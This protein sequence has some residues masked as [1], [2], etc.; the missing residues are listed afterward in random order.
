LFVKDDDKRRRNF[1]REPPDMQLCPWLDY[2][3]RLLPKILG[4][5]CN[6]AASLG[7]NSLQR[8]K[9]IVDFGS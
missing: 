8:R 3:N 4:F 7:G 9:L 6:Y 5:S 1:A 2:E